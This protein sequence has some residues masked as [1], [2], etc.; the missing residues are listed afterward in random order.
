MN[1]GLQEYDIGRMI[2]NS[3]IDRELFDIH[4]HI[5]RSLHLSENRENIARQLGINQRNRGMEVFEQHRQEQHRE[6]IRRQDTDRQTGRLQNAHNLA[7]DRLY[8][9]MRPGK[10]FSVEGHRYYER[11]AN[12]TDK[13]RLL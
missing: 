6:H 13:G 7:L 3:I 9:A 2:A 8:Q 12:R 1:P 5:D 4:A 10:R 11:R